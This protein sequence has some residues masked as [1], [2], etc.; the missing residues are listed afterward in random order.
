MPKNDL[1]KDLKI[2]ELGR[3]WAKLNI[4]IEIVVANFVFSQNAVG[5][6]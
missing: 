6:I 2:G 1:L 5:T 4:N 3:I